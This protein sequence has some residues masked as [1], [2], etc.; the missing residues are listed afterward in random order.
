MTTDVTTASGPSWGSG[1]RHW[2]TGLRKLVTINAAEMAMAAARKMN[3]AAG[4]TAVHSTP[5]TAEA[6]R[7]PADWTVASSP[8]AE[9]RN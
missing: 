6:I 3:A 4:E 5:A 8:N 9:P 2:L 7:F 1:G